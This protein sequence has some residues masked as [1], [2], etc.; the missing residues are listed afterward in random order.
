MTCR[1][2]STV[3]LQAW[4]T[5]TMRMRGTDRG[6]QAAY[7]QLLGP[8]EGLGGD[9]LTSFLAVRPGQAGHINKHVEEVV[10][11]PGDHDD[12]VN[13][14]EEDHHDCWVT[15]ALYNKLNCYKTF[16]IR[17]VFPINLKIKFCKI[18]I[19]SP[20][21]WPWI[22]VHKSHRRLGQFVGATCAPKKKWTQYFAQ[23]NRNNMQRNVC[24]IV[25]KISI[26]NNVCRKLHIQSY[27]HS[28]HAF[29]G[30]LVMLVYFWISCNY[31]Q[32]FVFILPHPFP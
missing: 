23:C 20:F 10:E 14:L 15:N 12:V 9:L 3:M 8:C 25:K 26:V 32:I 17:S 2:W 7:S 27:T 29:P 11:G 24:K 19:N 13:V 28:S 16:N 6:H 22:C 5:E 30:M 18:D 4:Q 1:R 21:K 31:Q